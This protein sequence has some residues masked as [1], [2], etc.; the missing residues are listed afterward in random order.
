MMGL[1]ETGWQ[2]FKDERLE[3]A[4]GCQVLMER[5][6]RSGSRPCQGLASSEGFS[7]FRDL[8]LI[9]NF[10]KLCVVST[11]LGITDGFATI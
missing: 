6:G 11:I 4:F 7:S 3:N 5:A 1:L 8:I 9:L 2:G 10:I